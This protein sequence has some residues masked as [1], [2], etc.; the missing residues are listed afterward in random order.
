V[1]GTLKIAIPMAGLGTR[2]RP[3]TWSKP[4]PLVALAGRKLIDYVLDM[5]KT[6]PDPSA[7]EFVFIT[8]L[9][10]EQINVHMCENYPDLKISY[11]VQPEMRGQS[12]AIYLA[13]EHLTGPTIVAFAD[14]LVET[15][16]SFLGDTTDD[17]V[18]WVKA[19]PDPRRFGVTVLNEEGWVKRIIEKP[20]DV[21]NN[22]AVVGFYFFQHGEDLVSAI[23][24]QV[25]QGVTLKGE[26]YLADAVNIMLDGGMKM[27]T[28][29]VEVW[30]DAGTSESIL[31]TNR[32]LLEHGRDNSAAL[33]PFPNTVIIPPVNIDPHA[34]VHDS[35]IGPHVSM[36]ADCQIEGSII[37][38]SIVD[39]GAQVT[40]S[41]LEGSLLGRNVQV[42]GQALHLNLGD[43]SWAMR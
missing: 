25:K 16:F 28:Q 42:A 31:S 36:S 24:Q 41:L 9:M 6:V 8:G 11:V 35:V 43:Q 4:K 20:Q 38:D 1:N 2:L 21:T 10:G 15:D 23:E 26:Y 33:P 18:A 32:Y 13:R 3:Q 14:T 39:E 27:H 7:V 19:V 37:R 22:L 30:L 17:A 29:P 12:D 40:N 5:F 34:D